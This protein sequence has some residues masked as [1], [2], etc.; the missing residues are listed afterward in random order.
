[1]LPRFIGK[2][3]LATGFLLGTY[4]LT[5]ERPV[6]LQSGLGLIAAGVLAAG[7]GLYRA[8]AS[9]S[10]QVNQRSEETGR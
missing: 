10:H 9:R 7:Y 2:I 4:G 3:F 8:L 5:D 6:L 1:M